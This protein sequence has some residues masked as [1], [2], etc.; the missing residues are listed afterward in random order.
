MVKQSQVTYQPGTH[1]DQFLQL[2]MHLIGFTYTA[3]PFVLTA[4]HCPESTGLDQWLVCVS[5]AQGYGQTH[6]WVQG[7]E[8][9]PQ[10]M[11]A[12]LPQWVLAMADQIKG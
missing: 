11:S 9:V 8:I 4:T 6:R 12:N 5:C 10:I 3:M 1:T 7:P 2:N